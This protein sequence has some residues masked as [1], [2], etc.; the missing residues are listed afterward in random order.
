VS[1]HFS[2]V[3]LW[4]GI[5]SLL[6]FTHCF[7]STH[8]GKTWDTADDWESGIGTDDEV[9]GGARGAAG[10]GADD[11]SRASS[12]VMSWNLVLGSYVWCLS[13]SLN[14]SADPSGPASARRT[15][16]AP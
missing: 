3:A 2:V 8:T 16:E 9:D 1:L 7:P 13:N 15:R 4:S 14:I 10:E 6:E 12:V 11:D 5:F